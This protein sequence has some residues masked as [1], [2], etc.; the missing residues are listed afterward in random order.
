MSIVNKYFSKKE[1]IKNNILKVF[2]I[3]YGINNIKTLLNIRDTNFGDFYSQH[4]TQP[5]LKNT[6][7][8][9]WDKEYEKI[10]TACYNKFRADNDIGTTI[11][12]YWQLLNGN[13][14]PSKRMGKYF[15]ITNDNKKLIQTIRK[16][17]YKII[18]I[19]D[20][21]TS[22]DFEKAKNEINIALNNVL[23]KKSLFEI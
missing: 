9:L 10:D 4:L 1:Y 15:S 5:F 16:R 22:V 6:F 12:R 7:D 13:F 2:N 18:C 3:R 14:N 17:K 23:N 11:C 19:N 21:D 8:T 20:S